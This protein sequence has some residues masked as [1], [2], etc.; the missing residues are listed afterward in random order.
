MIW[1]IMCK[2]VS[3]ASKFIN[4]W[5][6][7]IRSVWL[8]IKNSLCPSKDWPSW[9]LHI[10][11]VVYARQLACV[12]RGS[13]PATPKLVWPTMQYLSLYHIS[14]LFDQP[15]NEMM[16]SIE[17][18]RLLVMLNLARAGPPPGNLPILLHSIAKSDP[19]FCKVCVWDFLIKFYR[20][21]FCCD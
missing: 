2:K 11:C 18:L 3:L 15:I 13:K 12:E 16:L 1:L 6:V 14:N 10:L 8:N 19:T 5:L 9:L 20:V 4:D 7:Y 21:C 17:H